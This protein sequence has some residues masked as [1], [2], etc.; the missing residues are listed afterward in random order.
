MIT[1]DLQDTLF[2]GGK[3]SSRIMNIA[4]LPFETEEKPMGLQLETEGA[5]GPRH[6]WRLASEHLHVAGI[7]IA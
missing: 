3:A 5:G 4:R 2:R 6:R 1:K 7:L